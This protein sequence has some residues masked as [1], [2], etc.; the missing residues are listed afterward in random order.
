MVADAGVRFIEDAYYNTRFLNMN[1]K[2]DGPD[3]TGAGGGKG[4]A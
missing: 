4:Y 1:R 2:K 3:F